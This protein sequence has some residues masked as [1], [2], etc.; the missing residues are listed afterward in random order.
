M[1]DVRMLSLERNLQILTLVCLQRWKV[2]VGLSNPELFGRLESLTMDL[3][4][5]HSDY[6]VFLVPPLLP[7]EIP[8]FFSSPADLP[9][10]CRI[11]EIGLAS[12][13]AAIELKEIKQ[14]LSA[15]TIG[16]APRKK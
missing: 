16:T 8:I 13:A 3:N 6:A 15:G 10:I 14:E 9:Q 5:L 4:N 11:R 7:E 12:R 1:G 2:R